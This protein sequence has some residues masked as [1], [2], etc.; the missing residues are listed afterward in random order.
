M[1]KWKIA[2]L[3]AKRGIENAH[4]LQLAL[5]LKSPTVAQGLYQGTWR[6][7]SFEILDLICEKL[8]ITPN[9][10]F[11]VD[12]LLIK[13]KKTQKEKERPDWICK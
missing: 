12:K 10:L 4:Q 7:I 5:G 13:K 1:L 9:D 8:T 3:C 2:E 11:G 6:R